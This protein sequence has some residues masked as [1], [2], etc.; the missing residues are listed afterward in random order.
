MSS[1]RSAAE[2]IGFRGR[3]SVSTNDR[4]YGRSVGSFPLA[5]ASGNPYANGVGHYRKSCTVALVVAAVVVA[6]LVAVVVEAVVLAVG[7]I[8]AVG[9]VVVLETGRWRNPVVPRVEV[10]GLWELWLVLA[11][12]TR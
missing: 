3:L 4:R 2:V 9:S 8:V 1:K 10:V 12:P 11:P 5:G 6:L 7:T